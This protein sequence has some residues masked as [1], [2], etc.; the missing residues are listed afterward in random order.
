[1]TKSFHNSMKLLTDY[2]K[3]IFRMII[4]FTKYV[5][6]SKNAVCIQY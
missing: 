5:L 3:C 1:M 6:H 2:C 4:I